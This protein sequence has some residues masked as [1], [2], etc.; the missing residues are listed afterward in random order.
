MTVQADDLPPLLQRRWAAMVTDAGGEDEALRRL[1][2]MARRPARRAL[3]TPASLG[4][5]IVEVTIKMPR[6]DAEAMRRTAEGLGFRR[7][8]WI[9]AVATAKLRTAAYYPAT[10][11][12]AHSQVRYELQSIGSVL[13]GAAQRADKEGAQAAASA[14]L[15]AYADARGQL[16]ALRWA[17]A[18]ALLY[19]EDPDA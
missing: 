14:L 9:R 12:K 19:W 4:E 18:G 7:A 17:M 13:H 8:E 11:F 16:A 6:K 1:L 10:E 2:I 15:S 3:I 5:D